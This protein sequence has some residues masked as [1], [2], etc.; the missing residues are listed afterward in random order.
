LRLHAGLQINAIATRKRTFGLR[1]AVSCGCA[2]DRDVAEAAL[3]EIAGR[4]DALLI[5]Q[6]LLR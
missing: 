5:T 6:R 1:K 3:V 2:E 4:R